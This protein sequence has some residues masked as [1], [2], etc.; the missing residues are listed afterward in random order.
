MP[1]KIFEHTADV[2]IIVEAKSRE[3]IYEEAGRAMFSIIGELSKIE[4]KD[5]YEFEIE[6]DSYDALLVDFLSELLFLH[7]TNNSLFSKFKVRIKEIKKEGGKEGEKKV[8]LSASVWGEKISK[9]HTLKTAIKAV[10][11][12]MLS[13]EKKHKGYIAKVLFDI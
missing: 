6:S 10:T 2:G 12:H 13:F 7:E 3:G 8:H 1:F 11:Y 5:K 9:K 4:E